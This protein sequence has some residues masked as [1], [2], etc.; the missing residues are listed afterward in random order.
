VGRSRRGR[1]RHRQQGFSGFG[2]KQAW[3]PLLRG[4]GLRGRGKRQFFNS[5]SG[6]MVFSAGVTGAFFGFSVLGWSGAV[7]GF[8]VAAALMSAFVTKGRYLR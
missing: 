5:M 8:L 3:R 1:R 4:M 2:Q 6:I 7:V